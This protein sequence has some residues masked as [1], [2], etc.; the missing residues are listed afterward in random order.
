MPVSFPEPATQRRARTSELVLLEPLGDAPTDRRAAKV[1]PIRVLIADDQPV[2]RAGLRAMLQSEADILVVADASHGDEAVTMTRD[3]HPDVVLLDAGIA[4]LDALEATRRILDESER[5]G[6]RVLVL[7]ADDT[8]D[9]LFAALRAGAS[10]FLLKNSQPVDLVEAVRVVAGGAALL[11]PGATE[12]LIA[13]FASQPQPHLPSDEQLD[14]LT[15]R[16]REVMALVATGL[17][18]DEIAERF[19]ISRA[20]VKTHVSRALGKLDVRDRAQ[21]VAVA[22]QAGLVRPGHS[23]TL[24]SVPTG[25]PTAVV[26]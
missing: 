14:E 4:G 6:A 9:F 18:N 5:I 11:S 7:A 3:V 24:R 2:V 10:G 19:V 12:R 21:L 20:T 25:F 1:R 26:A 15:P 22:Y 17:S 16:E 13:E 23:R 8:S